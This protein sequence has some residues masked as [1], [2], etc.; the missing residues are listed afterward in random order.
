[1]H[2]FGYEPWEALRAATAWGG[3]AWAG[4]SGEKL[5]RIAPGY[6]ADILL[7]MATLFTILPCS[8]IAQTCWQ[9]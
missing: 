3:E 2:L 4:Q 1:V 5:G 9:S 8:R 7:L 6:L